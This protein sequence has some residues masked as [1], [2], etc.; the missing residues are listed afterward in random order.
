MPDSIRKQILKNIEDVLGTVAALATVRP[1]R[2]EHFNLPRPIACFF[3]ATEDTEL[4]PDAT[5]LSEL[6]FIVRCLVDEGEEADDNQH[7]LY[8]LEDILLEVEKAVKFDPTRGGLAEHTKKTGV[9]Y[10]YVDAELPR[11]GADLMFSTRYATEESDP[12]HQNM[13]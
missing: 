11:A 6:N 4:H 10:L 3:P 5:E 12:T 2:P 13:E 7:A 1:G 9:K 8:Q